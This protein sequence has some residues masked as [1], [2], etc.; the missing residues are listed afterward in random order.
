MPVDRSAIDAQL[1]EIGEGERWWEQREFRALPHILHADERILGIVNGKLLGARRPRLRPAGWWLLVAT[2]QRLLCLRQERF[3]RKQLEFTAG[4]ITRVQQGSRMRSYQ[5]TLDTAQGRYRIRV[6]KD[7]AFRFLGALAPFL[8]EPPAQ[9][10]APGLEPWS[11]VPGIDTVAALPGVGGIVSRVSSRSGGEAGAVERL[12]AT[13]D[14]LQSDVER[15]QQQVAFLED[16]LQKRA[17]EELY[18]RSPA[19]S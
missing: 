9:R 17:D 16:L 12:E 15:L 3:A 11:W 1:R 7:D 8:P 5:I 2:D 14:R 13:V 18:L 4:Q 6:A 19:D 10:L